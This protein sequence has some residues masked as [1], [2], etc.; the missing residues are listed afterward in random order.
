MNDFI[1]PTATAAHHDAWR[2]AAN[3]A[4]H[5]TVLVLDDEHVHVSSSEAGQSPR[6]MTLPMGRARSARTWLRHTPPR[7]REFEMAMEPIEDDITRMLP[8]LTSRSML[9]TDSP[10][11]QEI[12]SLIQ[13]TDKPLTFLSRADVDALFGEL[14]AVVAGRPPRIAGIPEDNSFAMGLLILREFMHHLD[15]ATLLVRR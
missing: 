13:D 15:F 3:H 10:A 14:G 2:S 9:V 7:Q 5:L 6:A 4:G 1:H 12:A 11:I 8:V